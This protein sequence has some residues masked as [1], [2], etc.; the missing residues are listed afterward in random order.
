MTGVTLISEQEIEQKKSGIDLWAGLNKDLSQDEKQKTFLENYWLLTNHSKNFND[1]SPQTLYYNRFYW[2]QRFYNRYLTIHAHDYLNIQ[3]Y[4]SKILEE[5]DW[6]GGIDWNIVEQI[7]IHC[8]NLK[9][10]ST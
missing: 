2:F 4:G 8:K 3:Q 5:G 1:Y 7:I 9:E 10:E 6:I